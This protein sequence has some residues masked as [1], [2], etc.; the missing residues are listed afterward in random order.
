MTQTGAD[1]TT[2]E[3]PQEA[4]DE[5]TW[6][7]LRRKVFNRDMG[8]IVPTVDRG[9]STPCKGMPTLDHVPERGKNGLGMKAP[10]DEAHL[11]TVCMYHHTGRLW[12][13]THRELER[14][15]LARWWPGLHGERERD[16]H[17]ASQAQLLDGPDDS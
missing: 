4:Y 1:P 9:E 2:G 10:D 16:A 13:E 17:P 6:E 14:A 8:C 7:A 5:P 11:V 3:L 12:P 15:Y